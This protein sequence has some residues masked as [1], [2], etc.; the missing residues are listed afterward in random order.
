[1]MTA[2]EKIIHY[3]DAK[4]RVL[5]KVEGLGIKYYITED[6]LDILN[7][8]DRECEIVWAKMEPQ[9]IM[10]FKNEPELYSDLLYC[11]YCMKNSLYL[12]DSDK[13][14]EVIKNICSGCNYGINHGDCHNDDS[15]YERISVYLYDEF[16]STTIIEYLSNDELF[17]KL[18]LVL[19]RGGDE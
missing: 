3:M 14:F 1:M 12:Y 16:D 19:L 15:D 2:K 4:R 10:V 8:D 9:L 11:P 17:L 7:W 5:G 13:E 18:L 6:E